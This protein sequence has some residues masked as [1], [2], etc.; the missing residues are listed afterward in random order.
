MGNGGHKSSEIKMDG[1]KSRIEI[2]LYR[3]NA[4]GAT[5]PAFGELFLDVGLTAVA[6]L[7]QFG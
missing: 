3:T 5:M 7:G 4:A 6:V 2:T 1:K